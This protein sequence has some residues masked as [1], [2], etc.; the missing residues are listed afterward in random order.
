MS[1]TFCGVSCQADQQL[2]FI[3]DLKRN[4]TGLVMASHAGTK[5]VQLDLLITI[6]IHQPSYFNQLAESC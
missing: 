4:M 6:D 1:T 2:L 5:F 3:R